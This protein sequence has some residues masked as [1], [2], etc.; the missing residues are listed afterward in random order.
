MRIYVVKLPRAL[1]KFVKT[2]LG[3]F[4]HGD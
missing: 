4:G 2:L 3:L 1:S